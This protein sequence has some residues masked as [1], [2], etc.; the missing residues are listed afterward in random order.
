MI[1]YGYLRNN[2]E[3]TNMT[4]RKSHVALLHSSLKTSFKSDTPLDI[5]V[6]KFV[7]AL[8]TAKGKIKKTTKSPIY[9]Q[10]YPYF[11]AKPKEILHTV[12]A[13]YVGLGTKSSL[14]VS[15]LSETIVFTCQKITSLSKVQFDLTPLC[16][17]EISLKDLANIFASALHIALYPVDFLKS[18]PSK[19]FILLKEVVFLVDTSFLEQY[20]SYFIWYSTLSRHVNGMRQLQSLPSNYYTPVMAVER[21]RLLAKQHHLKVQV[22]TESDL[23]KMGAGGVL[24]VS[25]GSDNEGR[26]IVLEYKPKTRKKLSTLALVGKGVT[27]DT[28]GISIKPSLNMH[29]MKYDMSGS[30]SV[31]HAISAIAELNLDVHAVGIVGMVE[32]MPG[33]SALKP[34]DVYQSL[35][36]LTIEVQNTD[37]EGRLVLGDLLYYAEK[38]YKPDL[39]IDIATLTGACVVALGPFYAGLF[40]RNQALH[41]FMM[42]ASQDCLEPIWPMPLSDDYKELLKSNIADYNNIGGRGGGASSA[43]AFLSLFTE[44]ETNWVHLD[45]AGIGYTSTPFQLYP[46]I[47]TGFGVKLLTQVAYQMATSKKK[48][49]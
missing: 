10:G 13:I 9:V 21:A 19:E 39:I 8:E 31:M 17:G 45:I 38:Q 34:G 24:A 27:F 41:N 40:A 16:V 20:K 47:A 3:N 7:F 18:E 14:T 33:G 32:N 49:F 1:R 26:M 36:G 15:S 35:K 46:S 2:C 37:A 42:E 11:T 5:V 22:F 43:A 44:K 30:A 29:E 6:V 4:T 25:Q 48:L 28:G 12:N 23:R